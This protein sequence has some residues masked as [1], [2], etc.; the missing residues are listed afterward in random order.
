MPL[1][2][3]SPG[4]HIDRGKWLEA[5]RNAKNVVTAG[6]KHLAIGPLIDPGSF[7]ALTACAQGSPSCSSPKHHPGAKWTWP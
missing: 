2:H 7:V 4:F 3:R 1:L 5:E 6:E